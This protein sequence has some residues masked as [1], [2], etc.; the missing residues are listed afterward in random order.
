MAAFRRIK[1]V[2]CGARSAHS[3]CI[4]SQKRQIDAVHC[5]TDD[6][7]TFYDK[8]GTYYK[9]QKLHIQR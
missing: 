8:L 1:P 2:A 4:P 7:Y 5:G 9:H 6:I 3:D